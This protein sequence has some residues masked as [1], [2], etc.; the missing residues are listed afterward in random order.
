MTDHRQDQRQSV[1]RW[2]TADSRQAQGST[3]LEPAETGCRGTGL[4]LKL[5][6]FVHYLSAA[7][8]GVAVVREKLKKRGQSTQ[9]ALSAPQRRD[10]VTDLS[11]SFTKEADG[12]LMRMNSEEE[13]SGL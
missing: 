6:G 7:P 12:S 8:Q 2:R 3:V 10:R 5:C 9:G 1:D 11:K 4:S 13:A